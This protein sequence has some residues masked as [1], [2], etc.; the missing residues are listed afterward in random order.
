MGAWQCLSVTF[1]LF[2]VIIRN[3]FVFI[4]LFVSYTKIKMTDREE[5]LIN[6]FWSDTDFNSDSSF[7]TDDTDNDPIFLPGH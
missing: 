1:G 2:D 7:F 6:Q 3:S 5:N 4:I